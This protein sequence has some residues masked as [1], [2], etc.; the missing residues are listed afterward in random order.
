[1]S[2]YKN[3]IKIV[4]LLERTFDDKNLPRFVTKMD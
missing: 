3:D 1:M 4:D 2:M